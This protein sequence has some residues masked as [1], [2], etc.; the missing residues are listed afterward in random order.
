MNKEQLCIFCGSADI[1]V[2]R[3][4]ECMCGDCGKKFT[5]PEEDSGAQPLNVFISYAHDLSEI[6]DDI[7]AGI[8]ARGHETWFD[9][10]D[11][12]HDD[13]W[14]QEIT[15]GIMSSNGV[16][17]FLSSKAVREGGVCL[18]ELSIA[19]GVKYGNIHTVLLQKESEVQP[20]PQLTHRQWLDMSDWRGKKAEGDEK[21]REWFDEKMELLIRAIES[22]E[23][24]EFTGQISEIREK[25]GLGSISVSRQDEYLKRRFVGRKWLTQQIEEWLDAPG[26]GRLCAIYGGPGTGKSAFAAQYAYLSSRVAASVFIEHGSPHFSSP[27]VLIKE[28]AFQLACRFAPYRSTLLYILNSEKNISVYNTEELF[29]KFISVPLGRLSIGGGHDT[30]CIVVDGLDEC[31]R[32]EHNSLAKLLSEY[33]E[34]LPKWLKLV[35]LSRSESAVTGWLTPDRQ[36]DMLGSGDDNLVDIRQYYSVVLEKKLQAA[37]NADEILDELTRCTSGVFLYASVVAQMIND[38]KLSLTDTAGYPRNLNGAFLRWFTRYFP[39]IAEYRRLYKLY[40]GMIAV[41]HGPLPVEELDEVN[42]WYDAA[43]GSFHLKAEGYGED[44]WPMSRR[45]LLA[46]IRPLLTCRT[47]MSRKETVAFSHRYIAEWLTGSDDAGGYPDERGGVYSCDPKDAYR[48]MGRT[49]LKKL[50]GEK[51][52]TEY[53]ALHLLDYVRASEDEAYSLRTAKDTGLKKALTEFAEKYEKAINYPAAITFR[54]ADTARAR[55]IADITPS[56]EA[57]LEYASCLEKLGDAVYD[58]GKYADGLQLYEQVADIRIRLLGGENNDTLSAQNRVAIALR[59]MGRVNES[60]K[61]REHVFEVRRRVLGEEHLDTLKSE[62]NLASTYGSLGRYEE[63]LSMKEHV[64]DCRRRILGEEHPDTLRAKNSLAGTYDDLGRY[65]EAIK[66]YTYVLEERR[67]ILG[68]EHPDTLRTMNGL[69]ITYDDLGRY[70]EAI[71]HYERVLE[72]RRRILGEEHPDTLSAMNNLANTYDN[73]GRYEEALKLKEQVLEARRRILGEEHP[74]TLTAMSNLSVTYVELK[75]N[76]QAA[77]IRYRLAMIYIR[78]EETGKAITYM[79][80]AYEL[81]R[82]SLGDDDMATI[83]AMIKLRNWCA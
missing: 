77:D 17:S 47:D 3:S 55:F 58:N 62:N 10:V 23:Y 59:S 65:E 4:G 35:V 60:L 12:S 76:S 57:E 32:D 52:L 1:F 36:L 9:K 14:R 2:K 38:G 71:G 80:S 40:L 51:E 6:V 28:I 33:A 30:Q 66:L 13:D 69:A 26:S 39:D 11:I 43:D 29:R 67:R 75:M 56:D 24:R 37:E 61:L 15:E 73:L 20:P 82:E 68:E 72:V 18:D 21:Y 50:D 16:I 48:A 27:D 81:R 41:S 53:Q 79:K 70:E 63:A 44:E 64:L 7:V 22:P 42:G 83:D 74:D 19:V 25:L 34:E 45:Q 46:R 31:T 54:S 5:L 78:R 8:K 49:W